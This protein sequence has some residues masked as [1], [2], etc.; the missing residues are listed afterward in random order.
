MTVILLD[1]QHLQSIKDVHALF[2]EALSLPEWYGANLDA[3]HD[4]LTDQTESVGVIAVNTALLAEHIGPRRWGALKRLLGT[5][6]AENEYVRFL[7]EPF[8]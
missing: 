7:L 2:Q 3:L 1:G 4:V 5:L 8:E 6:E